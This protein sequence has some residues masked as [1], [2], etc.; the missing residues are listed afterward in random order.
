MADGLAADAPI[1]AEFA[2]EETARATLATVLPH[3]VGAQDAEVL[4]EELV[5]RT[6]A[7][8]AALAADLLAGMGEAAQRAHETDLAA[9]LARRPALLA[10][11]HALALEG[12]TA[13]RLAEGGVDAV[14][15][16][17][18]ERLLARDG[19]GAA[20]AMTALAAQARFDCRDRRMHAIAA[21]LP[22]GL[23]HAALGALGDVAGAAGDAH[24]AG[25][26][27]SYDE[28][29][30]RL[31]LLARLALEAEA[32]GE[33]DALLDP[34][35]AGLALFGTALGRRAGV[36][37]EDVMLAG[38]RGQGLRLA[39]LLRAAGVAGAE[40]R[41]RVDRIHPD[42]RLPEGWANLSEDR[43]AAL[44]AGASA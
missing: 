6:R 26:R 24:A 2:R 9:R 43:A 4:A 28:G 7:M 13:A 36:D 34:I 29:R 25:L 19:E 40:A 23:M 12:R 41:A 30:T 31:A 8:L 22:A 16:P 32:T 33:G 37:R 42:D 11:C 20:L 1:L 17:L 35:E 15:S 5:V 18:I 38:A 27:A 14:L 39:L 10:H 3:L 44:L 21:E